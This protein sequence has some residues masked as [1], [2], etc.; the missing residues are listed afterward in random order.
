MK[1][2]YQEQDIP[3]WDKHKLHAWCEDLWLWEC[4]VSSKLFT[5]TCLIERWW[6]DALLWWEW[7]FP[8]Q[9]CRTDRQLLTNGRSFTK[10]VGIFSSPENCDYHICAFSTLANAYASTGAPGTLNKWALGPIHATFTTASKL[11]HSSSWSWIFTWQ[12]TLR[13][14]CKTA[15]TETTDMQINTAS[16][17]TVIHLSPVILTLTWAVLPSEQLLQP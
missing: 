13:S 16:L 11:L 15:C 12:P 4:G 1:K 14:S 8:L 2:P 6:E 10:A 7:T 3:T 5:K 9:T 17:S